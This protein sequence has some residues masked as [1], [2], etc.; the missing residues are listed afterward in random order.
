MG[1]R[2]GWGVHVPVSRCWR[3]LAKPGQGSPGNIPR[4]CPAIRISA[5]ARRPQDDCEQKPACIGRIVLLLYSGVRRERRRKNIPPEHCA[6]CKG[7]AE[8]IWNAAGQPLLPPLAQHFGKLRIHFPGKLDLF[9][10]RADHDERGGQPA[11]PGRHG[12]LQ[13]KPL[14]NPCGG[15]GSVIDLCGISSVH[16]DRD[17]AEGGSGKDV[18]RHGRRTV[19]GGNVQLEPVSGISCRQAAQEGDEGGEVPEG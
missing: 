11:R 4:P 6:R 9:H 7:D 18:W 19:A 16:R 15:T 2:Q 3:N 10:R 14:C 5:G 12:I 1:Y 8:P 17:P 13:G